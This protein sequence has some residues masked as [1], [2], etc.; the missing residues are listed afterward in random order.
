MPFTK[1]YL[2][3]GDERANTR[4]FGQT[5]SNFFWLTLKGKI[6][7]VTDEESKIDLSPPMQQNSWVFTSLGKKKKKLQTAN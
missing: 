1:V 6:R 7:M 5:S 3:S 2:S 4:K